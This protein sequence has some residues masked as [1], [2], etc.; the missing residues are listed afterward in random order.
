M[1]AADADC[2]RLAR[3]EKM[4]VGWDRTRG[5]GQQGP[6]R[7]PAAGDHA[8]KKNLG[9]WVSREKGSLNSGSIEHLRGG[10]GLTTVCLHILASS[11]LFSPSRAANSASPLYRQLQSMNSRLGWE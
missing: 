1:P 11:R 9:G 6:E 4:R 2:E 8:T 3:K 7:R 10:Q 5:G